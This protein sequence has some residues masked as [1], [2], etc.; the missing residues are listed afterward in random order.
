MEKLYKASQ[1]ANYFIDKSLRDGDQC[2]DLTP[3]KLQ[4]L[5]YFAHGWNMAYYDKPLLN[6]NIEAW[7]YGPVISSLY[8]QTKH[9]GNSKIEKMIPG[10][11][12][13]IDQK[14]KELLDTVWNS[15]KGYSAGELSNS[16]HLPG[17]PWKQVYDE[18]M[19][20]Y[21]ALGWSAQI[22]NKLIS[23]YFKDQISSY[24]NSSIS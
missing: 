15:Y 6:E 16:T 11:D 19:K 2:G 24:E 20:K 23:E 21:K 4:K 13:C 9:L 10:E 14:T 5:V 3:M 7:R 17:T 1:I 8:Q 22:P 12:I 18:Q